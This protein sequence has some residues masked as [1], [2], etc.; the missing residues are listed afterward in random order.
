MANLHRLRESIVAAYSYDMLD[1]EEF[2]LLYDTN[3]PVNVE[4]RYQDYQKFD[5]DQYND[6]ECNAYFR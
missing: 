4:F 6:D 5:L 1:D 3:K 2:V